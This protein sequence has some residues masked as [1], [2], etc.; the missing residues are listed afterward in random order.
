MG[1]ACSGYGAVL[2]K[3]PPRRS[4]VSLRP[5]QSAR[6]KNVCLL[7]NVSKHYW[8]SLPRRTGSRGG[9]KR[10][11]SARTQGY[12][13][14]AFRGASRLYVRK[15]L[16]IGWTRKMLVLVTASRGN[17][18]MAQHG[19]RLECTLTNGCARRRQISFIVARNSVCS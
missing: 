2:P 15:K 8:R 12:V 17:A 13:T 11:R 3:R 4:N 1:A 9:S 10:E 16:R 5:W 18:L 7:E 6:K 14:R 19:V